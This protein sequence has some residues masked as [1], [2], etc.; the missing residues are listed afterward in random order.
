ML[1][2]PGDT[3]MVEQGSALE[4]MIPALTALGHAGV[5]PRRMPLKTNAAQ[6]GAAGWTGAADPRSEGAAIAE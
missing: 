1:Y 2:S 3:I 4:G 5:T 6:R